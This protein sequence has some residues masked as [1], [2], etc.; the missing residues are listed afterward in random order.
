MKLKTISGVSAT[1]T[2]SSFNILSSAFGD[3]Y[4]R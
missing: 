2:G 1:K 3:Q 4:L